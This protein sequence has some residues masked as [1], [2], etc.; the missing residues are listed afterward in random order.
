MLELFSLIIGALEHLFRVPAGESTSMAVTGF[1]DIHT[2]HSGHTNSK[3]HLNTSGHT[4][5][6]TKIAGLETYPNAQT[7]PIIFL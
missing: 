4:S 7:T 2:P 1:I 3:G 5:I 6:Y